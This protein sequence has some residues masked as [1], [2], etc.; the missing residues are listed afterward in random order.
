[1]N[2][3]AQYPAALPAIDTLEAE[4]LV[5]ELS[6]EHN[7]TAMRFEVWWHSEGAAMRNDAPIALALAAF[8]N[9]AKD[10]QTPIVISKE[11]PAA[12]MF[13]LYAFGVVCGVAVS[14]V[15]AL[16]IINPN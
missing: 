8:A 2:T 7:A 3:S 4:Q 9:G 15:T 12:G 13:A 10:S 5:N 6:L 1:M 11:L 14:L 16:F